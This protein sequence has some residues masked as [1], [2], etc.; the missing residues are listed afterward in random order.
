MSFDNV[1]EDNFITRALARLSLTLKEA[2]QLLCLCAV[3][4]TYLFVMLK[5]N[6]IQNNKAIG[7]L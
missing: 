5:P 1:T 2:C 6:V 4:S 7:E 3:L